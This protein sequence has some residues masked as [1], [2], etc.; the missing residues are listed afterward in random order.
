M[1]RLFRPSVHQTYV[2]LSFIQTCCSLATKPILCFLASASFPFRT[3]ICLL[4]FSFNLS[5]AVLHTSQCP[6][7]SRPSSVFQHPLFLLLQLALMTLLLLPFSHPAKTFCLDTQLSG[8]LIA[9]SPPLPISSDLSRTYNALQSTLS[10]FLV[11]RNAS[12]FQSLHLSLLL[13]PCYQDWLSTHRL[14]LWVESHRLSAQFLGLFP[15][16]STLSL[17]STLVYSHLPQA[18]FLLGQP[19][20]DF[21]FGSH[22]LPRSVLRPQLRLYWSAGPLSFHLLRVSPPTPTVSF[23]EISISCVHLILL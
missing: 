19:F 1:A 11:P 16:W 13:Q 12:W 18:S 17:A 9:N 8:S 14:P 4:S 21:S 20:L 22:H 6:G 7:V 2:Y 15:N 23:L 5:P 3:Y 10:A